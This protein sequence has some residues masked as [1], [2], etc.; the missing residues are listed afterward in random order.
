MKLGEAQKAIKDIILHD[1]KYRFISHFAEDFCKVY[2]EYT[3]KTVMAVFSK[4]PRYSHKLLV[5]IAEYL[6]MGLRQET[7]YLLQPKSPN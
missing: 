2:H 1:K 7:D 4:N 5:K 3:K 6:G